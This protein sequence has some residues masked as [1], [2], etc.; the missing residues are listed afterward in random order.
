[1]AQQNRINLKSFFITG[2]KPTQSQFADFIDSTV[3]KID[4]G[5][6]IDGNQNF[7]LNKGITLKNTVD[8]AAGSIRWNGTVFQFKDGGGWKDL[9]LG[10]ASS[11]WVT[12][13]AN[14]NYPTGN[15][16]IGVA[17][18]TF[19]LEVD[20]PTVITTANTVRLGNATIFNDAF[21]AYFSHRSMATATTYALS[22]DTFGNVI[23]NC[24]S[25][26]S[27][28]FFENGVVKAALSGGVLSIGS[29]VITPGSL[30]SVNG[31]AAKV[32]G[33]TWLALSDER[34][35]KDITPFKDGLNLLKKLE[36][37]NYK[38]NGKAGL[39]TEGQ[40]VGLVAQQV[41]K[42]FPYMVGHFNGKLEEADANET[43]LLS[44]D[45]SALSYV[46]VNAIKELDD[47]VNNLEKK[48]TKTSPAK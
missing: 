44:L 15:V 14:I 28:S 27:I 24:A 17:S 8:G 5:V 48:S 19:K 32:G 2:A 40:Y 43:D 36:P 12:S 6:D 42:I 30:L 29:P 45:A 1:M 46:M 3:N 18:P 21:S 39:S 25:T 33:G 10:V 16:G 7:V 35:K 13:G 41:E 47:R 22:Q 20:L 34:L 31:N 11:Q 38:Y 9:A 4:D 23:L 26:R 37:V